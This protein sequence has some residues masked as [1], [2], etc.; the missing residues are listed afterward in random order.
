MKTEYEKAIDAQEPVAWITEGGDVTRSY[1][2]A[3]ER[4]FNRAPLPL[5]L[6]PP[7]PSG[8]WMRALRLADDAAESVI[9]TEGHSPAAYHWVLT[10][11]Q[12]AADPYLEDCIAHLEWRGIARRFDAED[13]VTVIFEEQT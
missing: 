7:A 1:A 6:A 10:Y 4:S 13:G 2:L 3:V 5:Y 11:E 8:V 9:C 12:I